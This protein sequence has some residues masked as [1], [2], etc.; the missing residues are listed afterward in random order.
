MNDLNSGLQMGKTVSFVLHGH[1]PWVL[2]HGHWP[3]GDVW[4]FE[5]A[6]GVYIP[7]LQ[8]LES[9]ENDQISAQFS[10]GLTPVLVLQ[11]SHADFK[12]GFETFLNARISETTN[13]REE[14]GHLADFWLERFMKIRDF[15]INTK[16]NIFLM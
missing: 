6:V 2:H 9:L 4:L 10:L 16:I 13:Y 1:M 7:L 15:F 14:Y 11:L 5:A 3:H 12:S 8:M